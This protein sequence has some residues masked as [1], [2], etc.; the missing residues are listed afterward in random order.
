MAVGGQRRL[1]RH[2]DIL[3]ENGVPASVV[4][5][6]SGFRLRWFPNTTRIS[7]APLGLSEADVLVVPEV[8]ADRIPLLCQGIPKY[9][10]DLN[11]FNSMYLLSIGA[12]DNLP[13]VIGIINNSSYSARFWNNITPDLPIHRI[14]HG[15]DPQL[16]NMGPD[17][18]P[19]PRSIAYMPRRRASEASEVLAML[20]KRHVL[21]G[22]SIERIEDATESEVVSALQRNALFLSFSRKEGWGRPP[23]EATACGC[24]VIGFTGSGGDEI[25]TFETTTAI[26]DGDL[27]QYADS[28]EAWIR[29]Y[30]ANPTEMHR[31]AV[32][33]SDAILERYSEEA[34]RLALLDAFGRY[35]KTPSQRVTSILRYED[36]SASGRGPVHDSL[37]ALGQRT[38]SSLLAR[39]INGWTV[40]KTWR[41]REA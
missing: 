22:W 33:S 18:I 10:I 9:V 24:H 26:Q 39:R 36:L 11:V 12:L 29:N 13:N 21:K 34:E 3:N 7:Y 37:V 19:R 5:H 28:V 8:L 14:P 32:V 15:F 6:K 38:R 31:R 35:S 23:A 1:Y 17:A 2:V 20:A 40:S 27:L 25:F 4:H 16:W 41:N 30:E